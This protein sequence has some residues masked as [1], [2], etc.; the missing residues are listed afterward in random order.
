[1]NPVARGKI[2]GLTLVA[3]KEIEFLPDGGA[4]E[5]L[6]YE[7]LYDQVFNLA[8]V[9]GRDFS[10]HFPQLVCDSVRIKHRAPN[11]AV[12]TVVYRGIPG[13]SLPPPEEE[14]VVSTGS[15]PIST[16]K[17]FASKLGGTPSSPKNGAVFDENGIH[18]GWQPGSKYY[19]VES[20]LVPSVIYRRNYA[21]YS[22]P[23][24]HKVGTIS[25][26]SGAPSAGAN[27]NWLITGLTWR[28]SGG[29]YSVTEESLLSGPRGWDRDIY[30]G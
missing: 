9:R 5:T 14:L 23:S 21:S 6:V 1:M 17:D 8:P 26:L 24:L 25:T 2:E 19:G 4:Q 15:A 29:Y 18:I 30:N 12:M 13:Q 11:I 7:C 27:R 28:R 16:H 20:Y 3:G 10:P 22:R